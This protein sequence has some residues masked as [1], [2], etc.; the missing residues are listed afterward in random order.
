M[1]MESLERY[2]K[3]KNWIGWLEEIKQEFPGNNVNIDTAIKSFNSQLKEIEK[4][5]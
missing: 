3:L 4:T 5:K 1:D 2:Q